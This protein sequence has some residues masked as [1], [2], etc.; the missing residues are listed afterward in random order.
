MNKALFIPVGIGVAVGTGL[1]LGMAPEEKQNNGR[2][3][4]IIL[5]GLL[6]GSIGAIALGRH[7]LGGVLLTGLGVTAMIR[8]TQEDPISRRQLS[9]GAVGTLLGAGMIFGGEEIAR[10]IAYVVIGMGATSATA[11]TLDLIER[12]VFAK[13]V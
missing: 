10:D 9:S 11:G 5:A 12:K 13:N 2:D 7:K 3:K 1:S 4:Y 6:C 8:S